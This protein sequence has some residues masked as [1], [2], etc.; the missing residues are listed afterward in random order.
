MG[1]GMKKIVTKIILSAV[2]AATAALL[3]AGCWEGSGP[4]T[5]LREQETPQVSTEHPKKI[6]IDT[7]RSPRNDAMGVPL[8]R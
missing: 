7:V 5:G 6:V 2:V 4:S 8:D 1:E 3:L